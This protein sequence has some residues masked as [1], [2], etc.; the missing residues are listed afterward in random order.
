MKVRSPRWPSRV[1][2]SKARSPTR[3]SPPSPSKRRRKQRAQP[4]Q[5][6]GQRERL[7]EVVVGP[8][9]EPLDPVVDG[10]ARGEH[11]D[12]RVVAGGPHAAA[13]GQAVEI[14]QP[15]VEDQRVGGRLR[16][17]LECLPA[18]GHGGHV[19]A[20]EA[21]GSVDGAA[22]GEVVVHHQDAHEH[23]SYRRASSGLGRVRA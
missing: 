18:R 19:V 12:G 9:I 8:G 3:R 22:D 23:R 15:E 16:Q 10:V 6:L 21:E 1:D 2:R 17:R 20:L 4:G 14:G 13:D 7:D 11:E 5:Q